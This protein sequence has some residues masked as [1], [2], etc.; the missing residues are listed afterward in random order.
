MYT[1]LFSC[2]DGEVLLILFVEAFP[3]LSKQIITRYVIF[4][5]AYVV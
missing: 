2:D 1:V 3:V 4:R 5:N